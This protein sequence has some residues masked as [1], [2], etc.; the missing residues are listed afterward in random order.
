MALSVTE[1]GILDTVGKDAREARDEAIK[2]ATLVEQ[3]TSQLSRLFT[4]TDAHADHITRLKTQH[5]ECKRSNDPG[6]KA[7]RKGNRIATVAVVCSCLFG[8]LGFLGTAVLL[9][10]E[11]VTS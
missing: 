10:R 5:D 1:R 2:T 6:N 3:H 11:F 8:T 4:R 7:E 9:I